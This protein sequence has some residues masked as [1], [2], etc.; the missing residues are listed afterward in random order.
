MELLQHRPGAA[1][2]AES[3]TTHASALSF[4]QHQVFAY[5]LVAPLCTRW[6][7]ANARH[8]TL[9]PP[10]VHRTRPNV[11]HPGVPHEPRPSN[12]GTTTTPP[13]H[14]TTHNDD[15]NDH[16]KAT[17]RCNI[18]ATAKLPLALRR[19]AL[20]S[21]HRMWTTHLHFC[22]HRASYSSAQDNAARLVRAL[23]S[24]GTDASDSVRHGLVGRARP[25]NFISQS[26]R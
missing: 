11:L 20:A 17:L 15:S 22:T 21:T 13:R 4:G 2:K 25:K 12:T 16:K 5:P 19:L 24:T 14:T 18:T 8:R 9:L 6:H 1:P 7:P 10:L 26:I 23:P 3:S